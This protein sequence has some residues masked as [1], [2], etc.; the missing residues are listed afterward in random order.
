MTLGDFMNHMK[1]KSLSIMISNQDDILYRGNVGS[2]EH[3]VFKSTSN[4]KLIICITCDD[5]LL[6]IKIKK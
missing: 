3:S 4:D 6:H 5:N 1:H 2:Y